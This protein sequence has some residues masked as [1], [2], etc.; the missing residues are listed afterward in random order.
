MPACLYSYGQWSI[1]YQPRHCKGPSL[2][3]NP[4]HVKV[5]VKA[6]PN[7]PSRHSKFTSVVRGCGWSKSRPSRF[8]TWV[9]APLPNAQEAN[10]PP[11]LGL[12]W[13]RDEKISYRWQVLNPGYRETCCA[14][15][16][17]LRY[18]A[19]QPKYDLTEIRTRVLPT[20][21]FPFCNS[22]SCSLRNWQCQH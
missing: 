10:C 18:S 5:N 13:C 17:R 14:P 16:H 15:L 2:Q 9:W 20:P 3:T 21:L 4:K 12:D 6:V 8:T 11:G 19:P 7:M 22:A 1:W